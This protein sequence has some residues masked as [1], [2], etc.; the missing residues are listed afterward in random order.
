MRRKSFLALLAVI[1]AG[2]AVTPALA[3]ADEECGQHRTFRLGDELGLAGHGRL[4]GSV[5]GN[6]HAVEILA[7][8]AFL[9]AVDISGDT[10][11]VCRGNGRN[12][13]RDSDGH[14][15]TICTGSGGAK[16][17]GGEFRFGLFAH[18]AFVR[19]PAGLE[20][21]VT[22]VGRWRLRGGADEEG[23]RRPRRPDRPDIRPDRPADVDEHGDEIEVE[24][25]DELGEEF[26]G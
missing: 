6:G 10:E 26:G 21:V 20:G 17:T 14:E 16:I 18:R 22:A 9:K 12:G 13:E 2:L 15:V 7:R 25:G 23:F 8:G 24:L 5:D 19:F 1:T 4:H 11:V 3:E